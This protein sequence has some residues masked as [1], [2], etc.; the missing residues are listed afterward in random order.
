[1]LD[2]VEA[3]LHRRFPDVTTTRFER[4]ENLE[5]AETPNRQRYEEWA[6]GVEAV[7]L[8]VGD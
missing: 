5:V 1:M 2:V 3:E 6:S 7:V 4:R 8:A